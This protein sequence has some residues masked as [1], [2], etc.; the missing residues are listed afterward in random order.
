M[1]LIAG[2]GNPGRKYAGTR[3][4]VGFRVIDELSRRWQIDLSRKRFNGLV[5]DGRICN[6]QAMMLK[7]MTYM[8]RSGRCVGEALTFYK[9]PLENLLV[10]YDDMALP[11]GQLRIRAKGSAGGHNGLTSVIGWVGSDRFPRLRMG[12]GSGRPGDSVNHVLGGF[13]EEEE[14]VMSK[15]VARAADAVEC[16]LMNGVDETMNQFNR[17]LEIEGEEN[18]R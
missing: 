9:Q 16:W 18:S 8:N 4:N 17:P 10:V 14:Q 5:G 7:P 1:K 15:A 11:T 3:H 12:I 13:S 6:Q 2:L